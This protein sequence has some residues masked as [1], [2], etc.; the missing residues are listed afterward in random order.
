MSFYEQFAVVLNN[1]D[2][3]TCDGK[4]TYDGNEAGDVTD[5][6]SC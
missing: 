2:E 5:Y 4:C 3:T 1:I 6:E